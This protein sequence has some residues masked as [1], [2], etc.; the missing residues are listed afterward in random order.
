MKPLNEF[1][2]NQQNYL[3]NKRFHR[4]YKWFERRQGKISIIHQPDYLKIFKCYPPTFK[5]WTD[6]IKKQNV[7]S[8][9][10]KKGHGGYIK[11][12]FW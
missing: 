7:Y 4:A 2:E 9:I 12:A 8:M 3:C 6:L 5:V 1:L 10:S 11:I